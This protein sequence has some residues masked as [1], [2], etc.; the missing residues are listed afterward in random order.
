[1]H[2]KNIAEKLKQQSFDVG[3]ISLHV[4]HKNYVNN[5]YEHIYLLMCT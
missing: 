5:I 2:V 3:E 1:M 4:M